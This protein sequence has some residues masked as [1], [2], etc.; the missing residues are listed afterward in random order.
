[1]T[2]TPLCPS[3]FDAGLPSLTYDFAESPAEVYAR[4]RPAPWKPMMGLSGPATLPIEF[5]AEVARA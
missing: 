4:I 3:V 5:G 1:M 2:I